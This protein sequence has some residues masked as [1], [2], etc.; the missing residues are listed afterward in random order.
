MQE[1]VAGMVAK[2][3]NAEKEN[4][5]L[6][7]EQEGELEKA[8]QLV[9]VLRGELAAA[10]GK[11]RVM[12]AAI[13]TAA[14]QMEQPATDAAFAQPHLVPGTS[15]PAPRAFAPLQHGGRG[16]AHRP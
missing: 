2:L 7:S 15:T 9:E 1:F 10:Q 6:Q 3:E 11:A 13:T 8:G 12:E 16:T 14:E 5:R 4:V